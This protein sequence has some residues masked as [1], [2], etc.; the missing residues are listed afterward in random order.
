MHNKYYSAGEMQ[1]IDIIDAYNLPF[2][3]GNVLKYIL[4]CGKKGTD[5]DAV[6]DLIKAKDYLEHAINK[7]AQQCQ[8][9]KIE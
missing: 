3:L 1:A 6:K 7:R 2:D 4:R 5:E 8:H 9:Q